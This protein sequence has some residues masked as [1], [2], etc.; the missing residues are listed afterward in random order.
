MVGGRALTQSAYQ[1]SSQEQL[2]ALDEVQ[3]RWF[4]PRCI[5]IHI[6]AKKSCEDICNKILKIHVLT[7]SD[8]TSNAGTK[9]YCPLWASF[10]QNR[11]PSFLALK[12]AEKYLCS[13]LYPK[14][15]WYTFNYSRH[16]FYTKK[17]KTLWSLP[18]TSN[19]SHGHFL[20]SHC[21]VFIYSNLIS[22]PDSDLN[23]VEFGWDSVDS[24]LMPNK[25]I[26]RLIEMH[27]VTYGCK[28]NFANVKEKNVVPKFTHRLTWIL[29]KIYKYKRFLRNKFS[30]FPV[31]VQNPRTYTRKYTSEKNRKFAYFTQCDIFHLLA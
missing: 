23:P 14:E 25:Y 21:V 3:R 17:N 31:Y 8:A 13:V 7:G 12:Q 24:L 15:N 26:I 2:G 18:P 28:V 5:P 20:R 1:K 29:H 16:I 9:A 10:G 19:I 22:A 27:S 6:L 30:R 4:K 11:R